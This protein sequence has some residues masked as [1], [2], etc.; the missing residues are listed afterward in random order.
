MLDGDDPG[1]P[2]NINN[3]PQKGIDNH[4]EYIGMGFV[5]GHVDMGRVDLY[6]EASLRGYHPFFG[7]P[8]TGLSLAQQVFPNVTNTGGWFG[9]WGGTIN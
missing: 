6:V 5:D 8:S 1:L 2:G 4:D 3:W 7:S 9:T